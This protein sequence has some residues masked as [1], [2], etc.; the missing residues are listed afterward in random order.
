MGVRAWVVVVVL[1]AGCSTAPCGPTTCAGC[2]DESGAC[3]AGT[4]PQ[5]G[6]RCADDAG[7]CVPV[8]PID[9]WPPPSEPTDT[10]RPV[11]IYRSQRRIGDRT[12]SIVAYLPPPPV[13]L[14]WDGGSLVGELDGERWR[15]GLI[16]AGPWVFRSGSF[17]YASSLSSV[18]LGATSPGRDDVQLVDAGTVSV[19][20]AV[21]GLEPWT[22]GDELL[23]LSL[24][25]GLDARGVHAL[26]APPT[27]GAVP[28]ELTFDYGALAGTQTPRVS[29]A[30]G[31]VLRLVQLEAIDAGDARCLVAGPAATLAAF[32]LDAGL[33]AS[34]SRAPT[35]ERAS[36]DGGVF[37]LTL[38]HPFAAY[39]GSRWS[40][41]AE[42]FAG[43]PEATIV[44]CDALVKVG[45]SDPWPASW[46]RATRVESAWLV[47]RL[48]PD[49]R[50]WTVRATATR[51]G[52]A[53]VL[54]PA[55]LR[56]DGVAAVDL[57]T[58]LADVGLQVDWAAPDGVAPTD[59]E[60]LVVRLGG[61]AESLVAR[62]VT[63]QRT[64]FFP[65]GTLERGAAHAVKVR[66]RLTTAEESKPLEGPVL[67]TAEAVTNPF[68]AQ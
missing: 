27:E 11:T 66:A 45:A 6:Q 61:G 7:Q 13:T 52:A 24:G 3:R 65:A 34:F 26:T 63:R 30:A 60:V 2:C 48:L 36:P 54:P 55:N 17:F 21:T 15:F 58:H 56:V 53:G 4:L 29:A 46:A 47:T 19:R 50:E 35:T 41:F 31:D 57:F 64:F 32:E 25:A 43:A 20:L 67:S 49:Q 38:V 10:R 44:E 14:S 62:A 5:C 39:A 23:F 9:T 42:A 51:R 18:D 22:S 37:A 33:S 59:Y 16:P 8:Q 12:T 40:A 1:L 28:A 68:L